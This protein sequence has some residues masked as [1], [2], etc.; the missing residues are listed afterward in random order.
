MENVT[1]GTLFVKALMREGV[2]QIF[3]LSGGHIM[4]IFY[5]CRD[6]GIAVID[7]RH[8]A[9]AVF[10]ADAYARVSGRPGVAVTTAG[11]GVA[12][13][14]S[15][16]AEALYHGTPL[17]HIGGAAHLSRADTG[18]EQDINSL[19]LMGAVSKW[20]RRITHA[21]RVPEYVSMAYRQALTPTQGP[22]FLEMGRDLMFGE[23]SP[24]DVRFPKAYR[25]EAEPYGDPRLAEAAADLLVAAERPVMMIGFGARFSGHHQQD[26]AELATYLQIPVSVHTTCKGLFA[27]EEENALFRMAG[28]QAGADVALLL[29]V[30]NDFT[31]NKCRPPIFAEDVKLIQVNPDASKIGFNAPADIGIVGG[32]GP[33]AHQILA[34]V[35]SRAARRGPT[36]WVKAA[37]ELVAEVERPFTD[38]YTS[39][40]IP[41]NPGRC[42]HEVSQFLNS[43]GRDWTVVCD[44]GDAG[45]WMRRAATAR[46]PGQIITM[47]PHGTLGCGPGFALGA[48]V[49]NRKPVLYY[50]GD[51]SFGFYAMEFDTFCRFGVPVVCVIS[52][53]SAWGMIKYGQSIF[54]PHLVEPGCVGLDLHPM[55]A[56]EK[57]VA[58]WDGYG[59]RVTRPEDIGSAIRRGYA[60]GKPSIINV[61]TSRESSS[62]A[63]RKLVSFE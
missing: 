43:D 9:T 51:G 19:D 17:V 49:A 23:V 41:M 30:E 12:N 50:T 39:D 15:A 57:M 40:E 16:M 25:T 58:M 37:R 45:V 42:A 35:K 6:E 29:H 34:A 36:E 59:E 14:S 52:N 27:D 61:E 60:S 13:T 1:G 11:P 48:W 26:V 8:E 5:G 28:A 54:H 7:V 32:A 4:P 44:G 22:V 3:S 62:P 33:V 18:E 24:Q 10:A 46:R 53:D 31:I 47:G 20:A 38:A 21:R 55:R 56:Y 2:E 63:T